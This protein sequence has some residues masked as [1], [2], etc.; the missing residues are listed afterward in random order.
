MAITREADAGLSHHHQDGHGHTFRIIPIVT[1]TAEIRRSFDNNH[2]RHD[3][4]YHALELGRK[5]KSIEGKNF[6]GYYVKHE[7][8]ET[9]GVVWRIYPAM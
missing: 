1:R 4:Q 8:R 6:G 3:R 9:E 7:K 5:L 2:R